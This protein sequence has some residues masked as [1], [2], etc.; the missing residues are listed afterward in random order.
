MNKIKKILKLLLK[1]FIPDQFKTNIRE[2]FQIAKKNND[3]KLHFYRY[4]VVKDNHNLSR[5]DDFVRQMS[6]IFREMRIDESGR[7]I[8]PYDGKITRT[9]P[10]GYLNI[11]SMTPDFG[12]IASSSLRCLENKLIFCKNSGFKNTELNMIRAI[13]ELNQRIAY[14]LKNKRNDDI[15]N[16]IPK[17]LNNSPKTMEEAMQKI[18]FY[19]AL[20][21]QCRH[22]H[23]GLGRLDKI[24]HPY[25]REDINKH[26]LTLASAKK[27]IK[28]FCLTIHRDVLTKSG[29]MK[30]DT[31]E[32]ILL[33]GIDEKGNLVDNELT[34]LFLEAIG[35]LDI[36]TPKLILRVNDNTSH[37][38]WQKA[39]ECIKTGCGSP[40]LMNENLIMNNMIKF[41]Y[42]KDD[43]SEVG[44][45]ACWEPLIIGKSFDQNNSLPSIIAVKPLNHQLLSGKN[46]KSFGDLFSDYKIQLSEA[47][48]EGVYDL[49]LDCSPL[50]TLFMEDCI[51]REK[52]YSEGG[53]RYAYH[54]MQVL[55]LP[56]AINS[57]FNLKNYVF[58]QKYFT[59]DDCR[60]AITEN[61]EGHNDMMKVFKNN[62]KQFGAEDDEVMRLTND[63]LSVI[64]ETADKCKING[65]KIKIGISS[66]N[67]VIEG[68]KFG[69]TLDGRK[70]RMPFN[71]HISPL[72]EKIGIKEICDFATQLNYSKTL[73]NGNV[74]DFILP[75]AF[76]KNPDKLESI[77]QDGI[78]NGIFELQLNVMNVETLKDALIH[79]ENHQNLIV[80]VW[81]FS[82]YFNDLP[83]EYK[84]YVIHRAELYAA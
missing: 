22:F 74:V 1:L 75:T 84:I 44:T 61:Y 25:F 43:V 3:S 33:G 47:I 38:V 73:L 12:L 65:Q 17:M 8:Y 23:I 5:E 19:H 51:E 56:N 57:L 41:G 80:R 35:E 4:K 40:L 76:A 55:S 63:L 62:P 26:R 52:D 66:P 64:S 78:H 59:L 58:E 79:P 24:L 27:M 67:F 54:G 46:Y 9:I 36:P 18:L 60:K 15:A 39:I 34:E 45:S 2:Q 16:Y 68:A 6:I 29:M 69:A 37:T 28:D 77:L 72:S 10:K 11:V 7:F 71:V 50:F 48:R 82:A 14:E 49:K 30:G 32:Y 83:Q 53:A 81:G 31:G 42:H 70:A 20:F 13:R 21:F